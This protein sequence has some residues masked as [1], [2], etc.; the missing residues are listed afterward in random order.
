MT[1]KQQ[2]NVYLPPELVRQVKHRAIDSQLSLSDW[3]E[4]VLRAELERHSPMPPAPE[5]A[6]G[7]PEELTLMPLVHVKQLAPALDFF[8]KLGFEP[9]YGSR[10]GDW[11]ELRVGG[12]ALGL[13]AHPPS[14]RD[15]RVELT[16]TTSQSLT[17][18]E[19]RLAAAGVDILRG[20][21]DEGFG[22]QLILRDPDG[23]PVKIN[24]L[25]PELYG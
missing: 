21:A 17:E 19:E 8:A 23:Y 1:D 5:A 6:T 7:S 12:A 2:F 22:Y 14:E 16:F 4:Q 15:E 20:A 11:A 13:L 3:V 18:L 9:G 25:D 24:Q 10:D